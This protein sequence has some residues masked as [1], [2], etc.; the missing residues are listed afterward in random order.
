MPLSVGGSL[1][2]RI[3][4]DRGLWSPDEPITW[5]VVVDGVPQARQVTVVGSV[6]VGPAV[7]QVAGDTTVA[8]RQVEYGPMLLDGYEVTQDATD[9]SRY[10]AAPVGVWS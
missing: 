10:S 3:E 1:A 6:T 9:P 7:V 5:R 8:G 2:A 4:F